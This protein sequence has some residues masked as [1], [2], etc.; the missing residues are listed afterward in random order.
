MLSYSP[1]DNVKEQAY[2]SMLAVGG[3]HRCSVLLLSA[4]WVTNC[5]FDEHSACQDVE[6]SSDVWRLS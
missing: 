5:L 1:I 2:P 4:P 6:V 3:T